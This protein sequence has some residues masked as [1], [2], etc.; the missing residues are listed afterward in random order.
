MWN[1]LKICIF[2]CGALGCFASCSGASTGAAP[3]VVG[4]APGGDSTV[5]SSMLAQTET[6]AA[7]SSS[8]ELEPL[9]NRI[10]YSVTYA[11]GS[12][13]RSKR[14][15]AEVEDGGYYAPLKRGIQASPGRP[16]WAQCRVDRQGLV[17]AAILRPGTAGSWEH[18][19]NVAKGCS[20]SRVDDEDLRLHVE[21]ECC[22]DAGYDFNVQYDFTE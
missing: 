3:A 10:N 8:Q 11:I 12:G 16:L 1:F 5:E 4:T 22:S 13:E 20:V 21:L 18:G 9:I 14:G 2:V 17:S 15:Q 7:T 6:A 19:N